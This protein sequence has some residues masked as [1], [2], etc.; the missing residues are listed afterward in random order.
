MFRLCRAVLQSN[1]LFAVQWW[2]SRSRL[3]VDTANEHQHYSQ[4]LAV[5]LALLLSIVSASDLDVVL[6]EGM[7]E[8]WG[9]EWQMDG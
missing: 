8:A 5:V 7:V 2:S 3:R 4:L 6:D 1:W 9:C